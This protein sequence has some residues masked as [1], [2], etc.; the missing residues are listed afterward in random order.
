MTN[1]IKVMVGMPRACCVC[2]MRVWWWACDK[3]RVMSWFDWEQRRE[4]CVCWQGLHEQGKFGG[5]TPT[6]RDSQSAIRKEV[7]RKN[8]PATTYQLPTSELGDSRVRH[9]RQAL[10]H[11]AEALARCSSGLKGLSGREH[12][13]RRQGTHP[14]PWT[15]SVK[16]TISDPVPR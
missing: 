16:T 6:I 2:V 4:L 7:K 5:L 15:G 12:L 1:G 13:A 9:R 8:P 11:I 14:I 10:F 3:W